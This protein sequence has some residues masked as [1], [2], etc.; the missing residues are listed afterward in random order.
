MKHHL[1]LALSGLLVFSGLAALDAAAQDAAAAH[2][3]AG[4]AAMNPKSASPPPWEVY[5]I[6][7]IDSNFDWNVKELVVDGMKKVGL[8]AAIRRARSR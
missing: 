4:K 8:D 3:A 2:V 5:G 7:L 6:I 1:M